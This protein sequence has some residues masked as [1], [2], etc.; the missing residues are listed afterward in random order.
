MQPMVARP[1]EGVLKFFLKING[2]RACGLFPQ[3]PNTFQHYLRLNKEATDEERKVLDK[4]F[5]T[6]LINPR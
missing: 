1:F 4:D 5:A 2:F 3:N 6:Q